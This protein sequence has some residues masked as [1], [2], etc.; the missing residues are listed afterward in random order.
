METIVA[1]TAVIK[2]EADLAEQMETLLKEKQN[3]FIDWKP[4]ELDTV[5]KEEE[6]YLHQITE[7]E[8]KRTALVISL[9][10]DGHQKKLTELADEFG[11]DELRKEAKRLRRASERVMKKN[12]QNKQLLQSSLAFVQNT[13]ALL[14]N[15]FQRQLVDQ[16]A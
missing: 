12:I 3:A 2:Q 15:N 1:L 6:G 4:E 13:L 7:L 14:T 16:K 9:T 11:S 8:K 5:V 10:K